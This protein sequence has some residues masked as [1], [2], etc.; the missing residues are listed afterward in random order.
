MSALKQQIENLT[1]PSEN[2]AMFSHTTVFKHPGDN[3]MCH[4]STRA[5]GGG[6]ASTQ[7]SG[8]YT[9]SPGQFQNLVTNVTYTQTKST[10]S[11]SEAHH[12]GISPEHCGFNQSKTSASPTV[13]YSYSGNVHRTQTLPAS[14]MSVLTY[15]PSLMN[16]A[17]VGPTSG[18]LK[19]AYPPTH[20]NP[21]C[22]SPSETANI[23]PSTV[24]QMFGSCCTTL[25]PP[26][27][28][29]QWENYLPQ[30]STASSPVTFLSQVNKYI[31]PHGGNNDMVTTL[32]KPRFNITFQRQPN[33]TS[34]ITGLVHRQG[35][36][37]M[38]YIQCTYMSWLNI[39][40]SSDCGI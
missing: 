27:P 36:E 10:I 6:V 40:S 28:T 34:G 23:N 19:P 33:A 5:T 31:G 30:Q 13:N 24:T 20:Q 12:K 4:V 38:S 11:P 26:R 8:F 25:S 35:S 39:N 17:H 16:S 1:Q 29:N 32:T 2:N 22:G 15:N 3:G 18:H 21:F 37:D 9:G 7:Y 14:P